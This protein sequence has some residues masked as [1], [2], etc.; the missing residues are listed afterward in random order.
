MP[1]MGRVEGQITTVEGFAVKIRHET[2]RDVHNQKENVPGYSY[3]RAAPNEWTV[4]E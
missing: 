1:T 4:A 3:D 2:G